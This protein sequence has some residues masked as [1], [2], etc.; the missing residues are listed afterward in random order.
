LQLQPPPPPPPPPPD[1]SI[2]DGPPEQNG[3]GAAGK[4]TRSAAVEPSPLSS[5]RRRHWPRGRQGPLVPK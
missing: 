3:H 5:E 2:T 4:P 1:P